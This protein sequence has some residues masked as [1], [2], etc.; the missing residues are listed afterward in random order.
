[1]F[2]RPGA[3]LDAEVAGS[4]AVAEGQVA[5]EG[6]GL[7]AR[8]R[9]EAGA[10]LAGEI[11]LV[12]IFAVSTGCGRDM[13]G[14]EVVGDESGVDVEEAVETFAEEACADQKHDG[15]GEL[16][17]DEIGTEATPDGARGAASILREAGAQV[18]E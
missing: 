18:G 17:G 11:D 4:I 16:D 15:H 14:G 13:E 9:L 5:G 6:D 8:K 7:Y 3:A 2:D 1:M 12:G 10:E